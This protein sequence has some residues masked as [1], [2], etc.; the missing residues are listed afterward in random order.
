MVSLNRKTRRVGFL[1]RLK[2]GWTLTKDSISVI[3]HHPQLM[4]FPLIAGLSSLL[5]TVLF[6][7]PLAVANLF[8]SGLEY[9]VLFCLYFLTTFFSTYCSAALVYGA[10]EAF[11]GREPGVLDC[12]EAVSDRLGPIIVWSAIAATV[13]VILKSLEDSD[14]P[15]ASV[16]GALFAVGWSIMTFFIVPVI[17]F[18]DVSVTSMFKRSG[19]TFKDTWGETLGAGF[20]ITL[21]VAVIGAVLVVGALVV[22]IPVT[23]MFVA[24]GLLLTVFL[25]GGALV[26]TY[27]LS[28]T[29]WGIAKT[30][31]YVYAVEGTAPEEFQNFDFETLGGRTTQSAS[32]RTTAKPGIET[33]D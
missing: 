13:S 5:F 20:G 19:R 7:F 33:D 14:N 12:L 3:R 28:Q 26:F 1:D 15:I 27:L 31:L 8:G 23:A 10:N 16:L 22:S 11:H 2:T 6:L 25:V 9:A 21:I 18:E 30:A 24:P 29:I 4:V 32:P 17:V